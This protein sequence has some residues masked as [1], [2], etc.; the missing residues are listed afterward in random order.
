MN[1]IKR[2]SILL[3]GIFMAA[4]LLV[5]PAVSFAAT[6]SKDAVCQGIGLAGGT[7]D[8]QPAATDPDI[9]GT[10]SKV[11]GVLSMVIGVAAVIMIMIGGF[12]YISSQ[13]DSNS[14]S[15]AKNTI[16]YAIIG[17]VVALLAQVIVRF[18]INKV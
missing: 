10:I 15:S 4:S 3:T 6:S 18:V 13:G 11:I 7:P 17:L 1:I 8:C 2:A 12:K 16:L 14:I 5:V 9:P